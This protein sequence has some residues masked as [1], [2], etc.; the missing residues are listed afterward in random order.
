MVR[1]VLRKLQDV[2]PE[3]GTDH[4]FLMRSILQEISYLRN[5]IYGA[6]IYT[7][8]GVRV[9]SQSIS[10]AS[11]YSSPLLN[12]DLIEVALAGD[13][14]NVWLDPSVYSYS[15]KNLGIVG[16]TMLRTIREGLDGPL[17]GFLQISVSKSVFTS[18]YSQLDYG[19]SGQYLILNNNGNVVISMQV[20][21]NEFMDVVNK[22]FL[23][24][25]SVESGHAKVYSTP[26]G[27]MLII[28]RDLDRLGWMILG[29]VPL[30]EFLTIGQSLSPLLYWTGLIGILLELLF[31][32]LMTRSISKPIIQLSKSMRGAAGNNFSIPLEPKSNDEIGELTESFNFML[33]QTA[34]LVDQIHLQ[35]ERERELELLAL[36]SQIKPHFLY[37]TLESIASLIQM[38][39][40][41][42]AFNLTKSVSLFFKGVLSDG[43]PIITI[44]EEMEILRYYLVIQKTRYQEKLSYEISIDPD[45]L[46][47]RIIKLSLQPLVENSIYHGLRASHKNGVIT[48][49]GWKDEYAHIRIVDNGVGIHPSRLQELVY[50]DG[51]VRMNPLGFGLSSV[52][53]RIKQYYGKSFGIKIHSIFGEMTQVDVCIP[54]GE[55]AKWGIQ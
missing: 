10:D 29:V 13:G 12:D 18:L 47:Q 2:G 49:T 48:I 34:S 7:S 33:I 8:E 11:Y 20:Y 36:Q 21:S 9:G 25:G 14:N 37:N 52:D 38:G 54:L 17:L 43:K 50:E 28:S 31:A 44:R 15:G 32:V 42:E 51:S 46:D 26:K 30:R 35:H 41:K 40:D 19:P 1:T 3:E 53:H 22:A 4:Y 5:Y 24:R 6:T 16:I 45:I 23:E 55:D 39:D 27:D